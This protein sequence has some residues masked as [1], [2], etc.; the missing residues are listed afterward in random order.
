MAKAKHKK[1]KQPVP[2]AQPAENSRSKFFISDNVFALLIASL[3]SLIVFLGIFYH[4]PWRDEIQAWLIARDSHSI[5]ELFQNLKYEGHPALW[6]LLLFVLTSVTDNPFSMQLLHGL[7]AVATIFLFTKYSPFKRLHKVLFAAGYFMI[8]EYAMIARNYAPGIFFMILFMALYKNKA[9]NILYLS[10]TLLLMAN[11]NIYALIIA[12]CLFVI[13]MVDLFATR[14]QKIPSVLIAGIII[15]IVGLLLSAWQIKPNEHSRNY[16]MFMDHFD[17]TRLR[18]AMADMVRTFI[19]LPVFSAFTFWNS[20]VV[21]KDQV[22][23][24]N[25]IFSISI[26]LWLLFA[27]LF[28]R[29]RNAFLFYI[30]AT[31]GILGFTYLTYLPYLRYVGHLY[32]IFFMAWWF[33]EMK[34]ADNAYQKLIPSFLLQFSNL[35]YKVRYVILL[36]LLLVQLVAGLFAWYSDVVNV[37]SQ[38]EATGRY[39]MTEQLN[40]YEMIGFSDMMA[41]GVAGWIDKPL[42]YCERSEYGTFIKWDDLRKHGLPIQNVIDDVFKLTRNKKEPVIFI[43]NS[44]LNANGTPVTEMVFI[45][46]VKMT[47]LN[48]FSPSIV[49]EE[50]F[51]IYNIQRIK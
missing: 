29:N 1:T 11:T 17:M 24:S 47:L 20:N 35:I 25:E 13:W 4:E 12:G 36:P 51:Y 34:S 32:I 28:L 9:K 37:F 23:I 16:I 2:A 14:P 7:I 21:I 38:N 40:K 41:V 45:D 10:V 49:P 8:F 22:N 31:L 6:H 18:F 5:S 42:Y 50:S 27:V 48:R 15:A 43:S 33:A 19:P 44:Q 30:G 26:I 3:Y 46:S 39:L